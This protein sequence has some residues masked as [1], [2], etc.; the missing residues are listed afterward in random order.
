MKGTLKI[1]GGD[2]SGQIRVQAA[3][4]CAAAGPSAMGASA[5]KGHMPFRLK[6]GREIGTDPGRFGLGNLTPRG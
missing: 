3:P 4:K 5:D 6:F 1:G 2:G